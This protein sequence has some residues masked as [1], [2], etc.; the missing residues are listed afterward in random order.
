METQ[1]KK[2]KFNFNVAAGAVIVAVGLIMILDNLGLG[3]P[4]WVLSWHTI[5]LG[6]GLWIGYQKDFKV[7]GWLILVIIGGIYTLSDLP[8][9]DLSGFKAALVF[10]G[11]GIYMLIKPAAKYDCGGFSAKKPI[12]F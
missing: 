8:F 4:R 7:S 12:Q 3:I 5:M 6:I 9:I 2:H 11:L 10:I 1:V